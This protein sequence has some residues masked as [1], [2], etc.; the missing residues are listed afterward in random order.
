L[1]TTVLTDEKV[2]NQY[3]VIL[4]RLPVRAWET[5]RFFN[6]LWCL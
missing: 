4:I 3:I 5:Y 1:K 2:L 6:G